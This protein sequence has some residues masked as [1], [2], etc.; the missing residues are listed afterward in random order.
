MATHATW[1]DSSNRSVQHHDL[2]ADL[3][4]TLERVSRPTSDQRKASILDAVV[5]VIIDVGLTSMTVADVARRAGVSTSLVH[6]H[7]SSKAELIL[8]ALRTASFDDKEFRD[9]VAS[10]SGTAFERLEAMLCGS[11]PVDAD[12]ASWLL[13]IESWGETRRAPMIGAVMA[14][15]DAHELA[16][17]RQLLAEGVAAGEFTCPD[18]ASVASRL[19]AL[20]DGLAIQQTLFGAGHTSDESADL[21][22]GAIRNNLGLGELAAHR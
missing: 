18:P 12:D 19:T 20:R 10:G 8:A 5:E 3:M 11:L 14:D 13:W 9:A 7:F 17:I 4:S 1:G 22:R 6:Y 16:A 15:L 21:L 2:V